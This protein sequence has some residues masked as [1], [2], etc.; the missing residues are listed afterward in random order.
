MRYFEKVAGEGLWMQEPELYR[1]GI[2]KLV[3]RW[4]QDGQFTVA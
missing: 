4:K 1:D 2:L 3:P